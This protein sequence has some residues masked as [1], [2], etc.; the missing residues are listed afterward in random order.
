MA[1]MAETLHVSGTTPELLA[2]TYSLALRLTGDAETAAECVSR[3]AARA[4]SE[5]GPLVH[6]VREEARAFARTSRARAVPLPAA[7]SGLDETRWDLLDRV[8]L[9]GQRLTEMAQET[10]QTRSAAMVELHRALESARALLA[11]TGQPDHNPGPGRLHLLNVDAAVH[12]LD[13]A[14]HDGQ[15]EAASLACVA[16]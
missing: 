3:A 2:A 14:M 6:A 5:S 4:G 16:A 7:L 10:A 12:G 1:A 9:R 8:A 13:D 11:D 15:P